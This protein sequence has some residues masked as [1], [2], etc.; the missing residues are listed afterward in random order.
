VEQFTAVLN[1]DLESVE[2]KSRTLCDKVQYVEGFERE[3][4]HIHNTIRNIMK[5][6]GSGDSGSCGDLNAPS[7]ELVSNLTPAIQKLCQWY[8]I[9]HFLQKEWQ[10]TMCTL[11]CPAKSRA[12][13]HACTMVNHLCDSWQHLLH[14]QA[15]W[16]LTYDDEQFHV[17]ERIKLSETG[18]CLHIL[19]NEECEPIVAQLADALADWYKIAQ[20]IYLQVPILDKDLDAYEK[21]LEAFSQHLTES[22]CSFYQN[23]QARLDG[24]TKSA[25]VKNTNKVH[26]DAKVIHSSFKDIM[27]LQ[28]EVMT[29]VMEN[30]DISTQFQELREN[31]LGDC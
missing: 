29:M 18:Q 5:L 31:L 19:L 21:H 8:V 6:L 12:P 28:G 23:L 17:L 30:S 3:V 16:S 15:T 11:S 14:D 20:T 10:V 26:Q 24:G 13:A 27:A 2:A 9:A 1:K 7:H 22:E 25:P 4:I